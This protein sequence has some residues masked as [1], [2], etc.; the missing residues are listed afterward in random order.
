MG[1]IKELILAPVGKE[2]I[3]LRVSEVDGEIDS[4]FNGYMLDSSVFGEFDDENV[5]VGS[6]EG[7]DE[8]S[9]EHGD[10]E[11]IPV[12]A[13][14]CDPLLANVGGNRVSEEKSDIPSEEG[15]TSSFEQEVKDK[16]HTPC[17]VNQPDL[18]PDLDCDSQVKSNTPHQIQ[19]M[20]REP[21][22][23]T[24]H[25][26]VNPHVVSPNTSSGPVNTTFS[27]TP[28]HPSPLNNRP[29]ITPQKTNK[30]KRPHSVPPTSSQSLQRPTRMKRFASLRLIDSLNGIAPQLRKNTNNPPKFKHKKLSQLT[31]PSS[32]ASSDALSDSYSLINRC[33]LRIL[34]KPNHSAS[35]NTESMEVNRTINI[36]NDLGF[37]M[38]GKESDVAHA[39]GTGD[40]NESMSSRDDRLLIQ[41]LWG[42]LPFDYLVKKSDGKSGGIIAIWDPSKFVLSSSINDVGF[43]A[44]LG[45]WVPINSPCLI[46]IVYAPQDLQTKKKLWLD[47]KG[48]IEANNI[49][50]IVM[51]DFNEV[52]SAD[53]RLGTV[54][55]Q[56][57]ASI[58]NEFI[59]STGLF[60]LPMGGM[61]YTRMNSLGS[62]LSKIDRILVSKHFV[63]KWPNSHTLALVREFSDHSPLLLVNSINDYGPIPFKFY[64]S[65][66]LHKDFNEVISKSWSSTDGF[67][68]TN[69][70]TQ[71]KQKLKDLKQS[72]KTWRALVN[73]QETAAASDLREKIK[74]IDLRA[75]LSPLSTAD[76]DLRINSVKLLADMELQKKIGNGQS[77][78][79]WLDRGLEGLLFAP[80]SLGFT[81]WN[82]MLIV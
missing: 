36:G 62:K 23:S 60:D 35:S 45:T 16:S 20:S 21:I 29:K 34:S 74:A 57:S 1:F 49:L 38:N 72:I 61:R 53:E 78:R 47:I 5:A 42:H 39:L 11:D 22:P 75:E 70:A 80:S 10:E 4:L 68:F 66:L 41:S 18:V 8:D 2:L 69:S 12:M 52:R 9:G 40:I 32:F 43:L 73:S 6:V 58:F 26:H 24:L 27:P 59:S 17:P 50:S 3:P 76:I 7:S 13:P 14:V 19:I 48:I 82:H 28:A 77:T 81:D 71:F 67:P 33:N 25:N 37:N 65:W 31:K 44:L 54:F 64:N 55:C 15:S 79:F 51:G 63:N 56:R 30:I 46:I